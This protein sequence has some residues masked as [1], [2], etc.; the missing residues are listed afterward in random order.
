MKKERRP[1]SGKTDIMISFSTGEV[2]LSGF[3]M[4]CL[5]TT[6]LYTDT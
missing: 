3:E 2:S 4:T 5:Q 6:A 1:I